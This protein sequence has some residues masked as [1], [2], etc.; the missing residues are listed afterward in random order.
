MNR[1]SDL[2]IRT[3]ATVA[4]YVAQSSVSVEAERRLG[5]GGRKNSQDTSAKM[6]LL[7]GQPLPRR[8]QVAQ[9]QR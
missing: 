7:A 9:R 6:L 3:T 1:V 4:E 8:L 5:K 2:T